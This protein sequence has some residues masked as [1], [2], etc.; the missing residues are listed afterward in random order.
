MSITKVKKR[1]G[2]IV[3]FDITKIEKAIFLAAKAVGGDDEKESKK[4]AK[5]VEKEL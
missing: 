4:L 1:N 3:D 5:Q 2:A